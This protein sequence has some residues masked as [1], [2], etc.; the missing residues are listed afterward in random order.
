MRRENK[1]LARTLTAIFSVFIFGAASSISAAT[2]TVTNTNASGAGSLRDAISAAANG[3]TINFNL[4]GCPCVITSTYSINNKNLIISGPGADQLTINGNNAGIVFNIRGSAFTLSGLTITNGLGNNGGGIDFDGLEATGDSLTIINSV[5]ASNRTSGNLPDGGGGG[6][7]LTSGTLNLINSRISNNTANVG[8]GVYVNSTASMTSYNSNFSD[9]TAFLGSGIAAETGTS[10]TIRGGTISGNNTTNS[11][12]GGVL[13]SGTMALIN[14]SV[15]NNTTAA[16]GRGG[17]IVS[18][19]DLKIVGSLVSANQAMRGG[20]IYSTGNLTINGSTISNNTATGNSSSVDSRGGGGIANL[21][22]A[23]ISDSTVSGNTA[24]RFGGGI[25]NTSNL[26][27]TNSTVSGNQ[28]LGNQS[29]GG[30]LSTSEN[31]RV[32]IIHCTIAFNSS[33]NTGGG[34]TTFT[35]AGGNPIEVSV[36]NTIIAQNTSGSN[37]ISPDVAG[38]FVSRG[39]NLIG[40]LR[41]NNGT[42]FPSATRDDLVGGRTGFP[43]IDARLSALA[44]NGGATQTHA[45]LADSPAI[46]RGNYAPGITTDQR[47]NARFFDVPNIPTPAGYGNSDIGAFEFA[48]PTAATV[49]IS[50]RVLITADSTEGLTKTAV[51][52]GKEASNSAA[53]GLANATVKM[54][55]PNGSQQTFRTSAFGYFRF[56]DVEVGATY[57][58]QA[59]SKGYS[60]APQVITVNE[61]I[62]ELNFVAR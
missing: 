7:Y 32:S 52:F 11:D 55:K 2:I 41:N 12:G 31:T 36:G 33:Q 10:A 26:T 17:G 18:S 38:I 47:G 21:A 4:A 51:V 25:E 39:F 40:N 46:D 58:F 56:D 28:V 62:T 30:G 5:I 42:G 8:G 23:V 60:F 44:N 16:T 37:S 45:L 15:L 24:N 20:G 53:S 43:A 61:E 54:T 50:G 6:I 9:N 1:T 13:N 49:I 35:D 3:D 27:L 29:A 22:T 19:G 59:N 48:S 57:V 34:V 14:V